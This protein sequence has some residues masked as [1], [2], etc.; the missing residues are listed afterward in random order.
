MLT[1]VR[2]HQR[3]ITAVRSRHDYSWL[4]GKVFETSWGYDQTNYNFLVVVGISPSGKT[5]LCSMVGGVQIG[6][7][8]QADILKPNSTPQSP[9]FRMKMEEYNGEI[10][11]R[12]SYPYIWNHWE[13]KR[14]GTFYPVKEGETFYQ[15]NPVFGH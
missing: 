8:G 11:L 12:G 15:T 14:L 3:G 1:K 10:H 6:A 2:R 9:T 13:S 4:I 7:T 5:A